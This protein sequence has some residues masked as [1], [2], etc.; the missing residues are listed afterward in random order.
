MTTLNFEKIKDK[1]NIDD[2]E[3]YYLYE[4][5]ILVLRGFVAKCKNSNQRIKYAR[6]IM[7]CQEEQKKIL[8]EAMQLERPKRKYKK[9]KK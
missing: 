2:K 4:K 3:K 7:E 9:K 6:E 5:R 1:L 8:A